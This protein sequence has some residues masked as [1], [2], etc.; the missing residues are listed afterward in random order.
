MVA[1]AEVLPPPV[2]V[3]RFAG[4]ESARDGDRDDERDDEEELVE[5]A[6]LE[7]AFEDELEPIAESTKHR[8]KR[9]AV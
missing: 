4:A 1:W 8:R 3:E 9:G 7:P 6:V 5:D 2:E